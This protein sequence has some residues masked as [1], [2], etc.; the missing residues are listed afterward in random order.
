MLTDSVEK[1]LLQYFLKGGILIEL[2]ENWCFPVSDFAA[3]HPLH[4]QVR[5]FNNHSVAT[6]YIVNYTYLTSTAA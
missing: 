5:S 1:A 3:N 4:T 6:N 2:L